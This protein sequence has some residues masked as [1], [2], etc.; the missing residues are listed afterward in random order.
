MGKIFF[1]SSKVSIISG[2][3]SVFSS[4]CAGFFL[5]VQRSENNVGRSPQS[6][7]LV[8]N[9]AI[10]PCASMV[11]TWKRFSVLK[12]V[13]TS[14][15]YIIARLDF[16]KCSNWRGFLSFGLFVQPPNYT[17]YIG[18]VSDR[19]QFTKQLIIFGHPHN[20]IL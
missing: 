7:T 20:K 8:K 2:A 4:M 16:I 13:W 10:P 3:H 1:S 14:Y 19:L 12:N 9:T 11:W 6:G 18:H 5:K 15:C 17:C